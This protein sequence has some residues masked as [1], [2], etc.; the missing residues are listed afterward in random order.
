MASNA[1]L[2]MRSTAEQQRTPESAHAESHV[3]ENAEA[4]RSILSK[5][6]EKFGMDVDELEKMAFAQ[7]EGAHVDMP[8]SPRERLA[9]RTAEANQEIDAVT[10]AGSD[11]PPESGE[12][13][14]SDLDV[15]EADLSEMHQETANVEQKSPA[16]T[17]LELLR[18][19]V[20]IKKPEAVTVGRTIFVGD[21]STRAKMDQ[22]TSEPAKSPAAIALELL[23]R[24]VTIKQPEAVADLSAAES[25]L[26]AMH[27][28]GM[29]APEK[30]PAA[31]ALELLRRPVTIKP[32]EAAPRETVEAGNVVADMK[33]RQ[34][35]IKRL[36]ATADRE[37]LRALMSENNQ[38]SR[39]I[40]IQESLSAEQPAMAESTPAVPDLDF[41]RAAS[42]K[43]NQV[44]SLDWDRAEEAKETERKWREANA[45]ERGERQPIGEDFDEAPEIE[46]QQGEL[47]REE[48]A[49]VD[50]EASPDSD[51][52]LNDADL[53]ED[54]KEAEAIEEQAENDQGE[55]LNDL[56]KKQRA[57]EH[58]TASAD[59]LFRSGNVEGM[60]NL[61]A[62]S[63]ASL[64]D[65][66]SGI[67]DGKA[68]SGPLTKRE[69]FRR[70]M[71]G[72]IL[73]KV[74]AIGQLRHERM[75]KQLEVLELNEQAKTATDAD[76][77]KIA[78]QVKLKEAEIGVIDA[79]IG[80]ASA[81]I[82]S[83]RLNYEINKDPE[84]EEAK[85]KM[86][87]KEV[88]L[89]HVTEGLKKGAEKVVDKVVGLVDKWLNFTLTGESTVL[90]D[91]NNW[92]DQ[93]EQNYQKKRQEKELEEKKML[94]R[95][96][97]KE[98]ADD[99][100]SDKEKQAHERRQAQLRQREEEDARY[101]A[102]QKAMAEAKEKKKAELS[103]KKHAKEE[104]EAEKEAE[105]KPTEPP[106]KEAA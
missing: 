86:P 30:S 26:D 5:M 61:L 78:G 100:I 19:P 99:S 65:L 38:L 89:T 76:K 6:S 68:E 9:A 7:D 83:T 74:L 51:V 84:D 39:Q 31:I 105:A 41:D 63:E 24:P 25:D 45:Q 87:E 44:P 40:Q 90:Q 94:D 56:E 18:R 4:A 42:V 35:E 60:R 98:K 20:T 15:A 1:A 28:Q 48:L 17:A 101:L 34:E 57:V 37:T 50:A 8:P 55:A 27:E 88:V 58:L 43:A 62:A 82:Q 97:Q 52:E 73:D 103:K 67:A 92:L 95:T 54:A 53:M 104:E 21:G 11:H 70:E 33:K 29:K 46:V 22:P 91:L 66:T 72:K 59:A 49:A 96:L 3:L 79:K 32:P 75:Q 69:V 106:V 80:A 10:N 102:E 77:K 85:P 93:S 81:D 36:A 64:R 2:E 23:K 13:L 71:K 47:T 16:A 12:R 14:V